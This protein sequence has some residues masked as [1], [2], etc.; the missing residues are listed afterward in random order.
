[1][2]V[3]LAIKEDYQTIFEL[4]QDCA[5]FMINKGINQWNEHYPRK[6]DIN[7]NIANNEVW[8]FLIDAE[9]AG[10]ITLNQEGS[11]EYDKINWS[12]STFCVVH[13]LAVHPKFQRMG[14]AKTL[15]NFAETYCLNNGID[16][17]RLDTYTK[18]KGSMTLYKNLNFEK[19]GFVYFRA[20]EAPF[21]CF[22]KLFHP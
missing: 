6:V 11:P 18:N 19:L 5:Q 10:T 16:S 22:E 8:V 4:F 7:R 3:R 2:S 14:I 9:I 17:I 20:I 13:R 15:M 12:N 21:A 1:M